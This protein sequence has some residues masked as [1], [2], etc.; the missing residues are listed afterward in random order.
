M[1]SQWK[2]K[3]LREHQKVSEPKQDQPIVLSGADKKT[4]HCV[5]YKIPADVSDCCFLSHVVLLPPSE[6]DS[7]INLIIEFP[8]AF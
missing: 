7:L 4:S 2:Y 5:Q 6:R 8:P 3:N 1:F